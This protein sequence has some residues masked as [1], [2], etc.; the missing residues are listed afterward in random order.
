MEQADEEVLKL[1]EEKKELNNQLAETEER[2]VAAQKKLRQVSTGAQRLTVSLSLRDKPL[3]QARCW[4]LVAGGRLGPPTRLIP[5]KV[6]YTTDMVTRTPAGPPSRAGMYFLV[7]RENLSNRVSPW[8]C[9]RHACT[10]CWALRF[11]TGNCPQAGGRE[12]PRDPGGRGQCSCSSDEGGCRCGWAGHGE[13]M[14][15]AGG[16]TE[17]PGRPQRRPAG[18]ARDDG[19]LA[20]AG[21]NGCVQA[22]RLTAGLQLSALL[23]TPRKA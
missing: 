16:G 4:D 12:Q 11:S 10:R 14:A 1:Q 6:L 9:C 3:L 7:Q 19:M 23:L 2:L 21:A 17:T 15:V 18:G 20:Q 13:A 5:R 22:G 8:W